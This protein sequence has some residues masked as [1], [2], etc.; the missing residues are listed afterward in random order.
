MASPEQTRRRRRASLIVGAFVAFVAL[1][2]VAWGADTIFV[3]GDTAAASPNLHYSD[4]AGGGA[5]LCSTRGSAVQGAVRISYNGSGSEH[6]QAGEN[7]NVTLT[8][9]DSDISASVVG[10]PQIPADWNSND[11]EYTFNINTIVAASSA[12]V[13]DGSY[14]VEVNVAGASSGFAAGAGDGSGRPKFNINVEC[15]GPNQAPT[16]GVD[17]ASVQVDEA[18]PAGNTGTWDDPDGDPVTLSASVGSVTQNG[19]GTW[20]WSYTPD[21]GPSDSQLVT[22]TASD[23]SLQSQVSFQLT[24]DNVPPSIVSLIPS[25]S[26]T[27]VGQNVTFTGTADDP[28]NADDAAGFSWSFNGGAWQ[29]SNQFTTSFASCGS[30]TISALARDKDLGVSAPFTSGAVSVYNGSFLPPLYEGAYNAVQKGQVV[31]VKI[32][33]GCNGAPLTGLTPAISIR[34][35]DYDPSVDPGDPS[36]VVA[37]SVSGADTSGVMR[38]VDGQY[39]Y[40]LAVPSA[41]AN[42]LFTILVRPFG[43]SSP[44]MYAV[45]KIRK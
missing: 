25:P 35:G 42:T 30:H 38:Q 39:M 15:V 5:R 11:D 24:V 16:V 18:S 34:Q 44:V 33:V 45:L 10:T 31:P 4:T 8:P 22:I 27:L 1:A 21:D 19:D 26:S 41:A 12:L 13:P 37:T 23:G 28:S 29:A 14:S 36:Y 7:L 40:N 32:S 2:A 6:Y 17:N 43:G 9:S 3:D 20:S